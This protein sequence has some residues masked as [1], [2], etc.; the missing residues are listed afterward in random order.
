LS[1]PLTK[2]KVAPDAVLLVREET[3]CEASESDTKLGG[4]FVFVPIGEVVSITID[5]KVVR[6]HRSATVGQVKRHFGI[7]AT[8]SLCKGDAIM[9]DTTTLETI[10]QKD[11]PAIEFVF[12]PSVKLCNVLVT[13][14]PP[15]SVPESATFGEL[16]AAAAP[17]PDSALVLKNTGVQPPP[18]VPLERLKVFG[19]GTTIPEFDVVG[20]STLIAVS[21]VI[22]SRTGPATVLLANADIMLS[23]LAIPLGK[24]LPE[25]Q[26][27]E[28][29]MPFEALAD[30][31]MSPCTVG[32]LLSMAQEHTP[33]SK[34]VPLIAK[35]S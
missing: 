14:R 1:L 25:T 3:L 5:G 23:D 9:S 28:L 27:M 8:K 33:G 29:T 11:I 24:L 30:M 20:V 13:G 17:G 15:V 18:E 7:N 19:D 16:L 31:D 32:E 4:S 12:G 26:G 35:P 2:L 22:E 10:V 34:V 6:A 21:V